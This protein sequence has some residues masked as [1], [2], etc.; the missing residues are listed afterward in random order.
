[1]MGYNDVFRVSTVDGILIVELIDV[2]SSL[3]DANIT[4]ELDGVR[5]R[6]RAEG[7]HAV[8]IDLGKVSYFGSSML[9]A[10]R[11]LWNELP[12]DDRKLVL[13]NASEVGGEILKVTK[14]DHLWPL[15]ATRAE[16]IQR[17]KS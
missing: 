1:M 4:R 9:E 2:V 7:C 16:A 5:E 15:V 6:L 10:I 14:F 11:T 3:A 12:A 17:A 13:C 8:V